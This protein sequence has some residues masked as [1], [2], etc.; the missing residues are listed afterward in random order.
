MRKSFLYSTAVAELT[1]VLNSSL[2]MEDVIAKTS[3]VIIDS[4]HNGGKLLTCGNGGSAA[5][6]LHLAEE[7]V[8]RY[9]KERRGLPAICLNSDVTA[10]T[11]IGN[12]Y[13]YDQVFSRQVEALG[14]SSDVLVGFTTSGNSP[15][16]LSAF[17]KAKEYGIITILLS[18][19]DGGKAKNICDY[20]LIVPSANTARIQEIHTL[21]LHQ[22]LEEIDVTDWSNLN[23]KK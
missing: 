17:Q 5:D 12:D 6:A 15:N 14:R 1:E 3:S 7:L 22:W 10:L 2:F 23:L 13:G 9:S 19:K 4:I 16:V 8:G 21:I 18:G 20:E 11:C